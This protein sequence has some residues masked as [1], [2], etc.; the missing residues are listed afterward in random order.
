[1]RNGAWQAKVNFWDLA[2]APE[3]FDVRNEFYKDTQGAILVFDV[4]KKQTFDALGAWVKELTKFAGKRHPPI[5]SLTFPEPFPEVNLTVL[6]PQERRKL[7]L[8]CVPTRQISASA[9]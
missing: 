1:V 2:G 8:L 7:K 5:N 3:F 6:S 9:L 4:T